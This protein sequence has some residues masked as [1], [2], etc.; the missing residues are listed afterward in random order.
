MLCPVLRLHQPLEGIVT[1]FGP[2]EGF[3]SEFSELKSVC[4]TMCFCCVSHIKQCPGVSVYAWV[5]V[6][7]WGRSVSGGF[8]RF[9]C[10]AGMR[11]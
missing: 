6:C 7:I 9:M 2:G 4:E 5:L 1:G 10:F 8:E 3:Q 11:A